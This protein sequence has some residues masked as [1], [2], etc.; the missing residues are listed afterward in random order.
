MEYSAL[1]VRVYKK[2]F[3]IRGKAEERVPDNKIMIREEYRMLK[4]YGIIYMLSF[5]FYFFV[6]E[7][8]PYISAQTWADIL[9]LLFIVAI[10]YEIT[11]LIFLRKKERVS[12]GRAL[13]RWFLYGFTAL[14]VSLLKNYFDEI[15][16]ATDL[17]HILV[18]PLFLLCV[19]YQ[20]GYFTVSYFVR[21][22]R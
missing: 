10:I 21:K 6:L 5:V 3:C 16:F 22:K 2:V 1:V 17:V 19:L 20:I 14:E 12:F 4:K 11:Y 9:L 15:F 8:S 13:A 18:A 7:A